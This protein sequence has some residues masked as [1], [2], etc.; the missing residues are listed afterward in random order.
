MPESPKRRALRAASGLASRVGYDLMFV[1]VEHFWA[2]RVE[3]HDGTQSPRKWA[4]GGAS[5]A[6]PAAMPTGHAQHRVPFCHSPFGDAR[7]R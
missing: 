4:A 7:R 2:S 1:L 5:H 3:W 6:C